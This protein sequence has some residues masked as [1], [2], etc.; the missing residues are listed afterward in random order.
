M[1]GRQQSYDLRSSQQAYEYMQG[2]LADV[3]PPEE[4]AM[5]AE[6]VAEIMELKYQQDVVILGHNYMEPALYHT[7][8]D[9]RGD[10]LQL[11]RYGA[12]A[13]A[14]TI[15]V[16]G[17]R[18]M[19]ETAKILSPHKT[20]LLPSAQAGCSLAASITAQDVRDLKQMYPGV[21]VVSYV[22][23]Y[24]EVKA[25]T[26][27][28]C[29][30]SNAEL[31]IKHL[32]VDTVIFVPDRYLAGNIARSTGKDLIVPERASDGSLHATRVAMIDS[33]SAP[34]SCSAQNNVQDHTQNNI[35]VSW[36][37]VCEVHEQFCLEDIADVKAQF[38]DSVVILAHPECKPEVCAAADFSGSTSAMIAYVNNT[39]AERYLLLTECAMADNIIA[40]S[41]NKNL[42]RMCSYRC[43]HMATITLEMTLECLKTAQINIQ[44][45][46]D[47]VHK[48]RRSL[49]R[50]TEIG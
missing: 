21:P 32:G 27:I 14:E 23:T 13:S 42:L 40:E 30:S 41:Y 34:G 46:P 2:M 5:K 39:P 1:M 6:L 28:C 24:A 15:L 7:V 37:G 26:D 43:P 31:V 17:V 35:L 9:V 20:V 11:A 29:T 10:S 48:A 38:G 50:M 4:L 12:T 44:L 47:V 45:D 36:P 25:E 19:A 33:P 22:N 16:C 18:F 49:E 3:M 8:T